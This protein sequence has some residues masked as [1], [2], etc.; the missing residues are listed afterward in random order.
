MNI[1]QALQISLVEFLASQGYRPVKSRG[2]K[3]WY[4]SPFRQESTPSFKVNMELNLW[5]DFGEGRDGSII[6]LAQRLFSTDD[7][8]TVLELIA[9]GCPAA[10]SFAGRPA[11]QRRKEEPEWKDVRVHELSSRP[12]MSYISR[13][14]ILQHIAVRHCKEVSY[15]LREKR[16]FS[17]A[18]P[19]ASG[20]YEL[21]NPY[22]KG[23]MG[24]KDITL[25][26]GPEIP[27]SSGSC[28]YVF[29]GFFD[30]LSFLVIA[31]KGRLKR[32][33]YGKTDYIILNSVNNLAKA[34]KVLDGYERIFTLLDRDL[35]GRTATDTIA[36]LHGFRVVDLSGLYE[37]YNDLNEYLCAAGK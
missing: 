11:C 22:F 32:Q 6:G 9:S 33:L 19:N 31:E 10:R 12:L 35:A 3:Y 13:R 5:Y 28:C 14:G 1:E 21:R 20:G 15:E 37:G 29:E 16:Y 18:F 25:I 4:V 36:G 34:L 17:I 30:F 23:C 26:S 2:Y 24:R 7:V 27:D 8:K